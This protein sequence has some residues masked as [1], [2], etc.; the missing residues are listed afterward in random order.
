MKQVITSTHVETNEFYQDGS[1]LLPT[2]TNTDP[3]D[4]EKNWERTG[5]KEREGIMYEGIKKGIPVKR[6][7]I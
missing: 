3:T 2:H 6:M 7:I 5:G 4:I 1:P